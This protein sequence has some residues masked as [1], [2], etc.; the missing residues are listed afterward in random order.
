MN[1]A[2]IER[3]VGRVCR[4]IHFSSE[5]RVWWKVTESDLLFEL[6]A[7]I[8]G[9]Q[10]RYE[11][12]L[13]AA[14]EIRNKGI[15]DE[16]HKYAFRS[17]FEQ[18]VLCILER[19]LFR[20]GWP[21]V[22]RRYRFSVSRANYVARTLSSIYSEG[23]TL[24]ERLRAETN[25]RKARRS[26]VQMATGVGPKQASLFLRN[27]GFSE[28]LAILDTH[29]IKYMLA[30]GLATQSNRLCSTLL[31]YEKL[32]DLLRHYARSLGWSLS[33]LDQA[34]WIVMRVYSQEIIQ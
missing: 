15:L 10:V 9:S 3:A 28:N 8:L 31:A 22:G 21:V 23:N 19:P 5:R 25:E 33:C 14:E 13:V 6:V 30:S 1:F 2:T 11:T 4:E 24:R 32:E 7:C 16:P 27:I 29:V 17:E 20:P 18:E 12:A 26:I 34:I